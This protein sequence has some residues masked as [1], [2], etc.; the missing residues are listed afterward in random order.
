MGERRGPSA[1]EAAWVKAL[2]QPLPSQ[3]PTLGPQFPHLYVGLLKLVCISEGCREAAEWSPGP[4]WR[5]AEPLSW[6][7]PGVP[8]QPSTV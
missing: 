8:I 3:S 1:T 5:T 4:L 6:G 7:G 2:T